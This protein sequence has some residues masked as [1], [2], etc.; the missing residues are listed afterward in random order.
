MAPHLLFMVLHIFS[1]NIVYFYYCYYYSV[2]LNVVFTQ[3]QYFTSTTLSSFYLDVIKDS[4]YSDAEKS[5]QRR[6]IQTVLFH[7]RHRS[8][9]VFSLPLFPKEL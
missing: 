8:T 3:L 9:I 5:H 6:A 2:S 7:V 1:S 4:L